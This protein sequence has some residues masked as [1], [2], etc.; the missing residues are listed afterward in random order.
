MKQAIKS[1][2]PKRQA[3]EH[4]EILLRY[5][6]EQGQIISPAL[7][8]PAAE[9][10]GVITLIDRWV[11][12]TTLRRYEEFFPNQDTMLSINLSGMTLSND[13]SVSYIAS[14]VKH[15]RVPPANICFEITE[16]AAISQLNQALE[17]IA[18]MKALGI[19]FA[20]DDFGSGYSSL[21]YLKQLPVNTLK[22]D[23]SFVK[24]ITS[25]PED[26]AIASSVISLAHS[27]RHS[28]IAEGVETEG[29]LNV[30]R[31][32]NCDQIQGYYF[33]KPL[34]RDD[35]TRLLHENRRIDV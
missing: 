7:F 8:I 32:L 3:Y 18:N 15:S 33:S 35:L 19:K 10:H 12:E 22:I 30:L 11:L 23:Q 6:D 24:D 1:L 14:L 21:A 29:Q 4:F 20:L 28:V 25:D 9:K 31:R 16:T 27:L 34:P 26:A 13:E 17:F 2:D 5:K